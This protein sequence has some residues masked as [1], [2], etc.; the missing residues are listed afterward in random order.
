MRVV[1]ANQHDTHSNHSYNPNTVFP[2]AILCNC[3]CIIILPLPQIN[4]SLCRPVPRRRRWPF[5]YANQPL[6]ICP[7]LISP[8]LEQEEKKDFPCF[9]L[10]LINICLLHYLQLTNLWAAF[11]H[12]LGTSNSPDFF[13]LSPPPSNLLS[14]VKQEQW[15]VWREGKQHVVIG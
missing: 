5:Q 11:S 4:S 14:T 10:G 13:F 7:T 15:M 3:R 12:S 6:E 9:T 8:T 2:F 1:W